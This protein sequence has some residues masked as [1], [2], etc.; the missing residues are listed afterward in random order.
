[1]EIVGRE[2]TD[3]EMAIL[4]R[5]TLTTVD[6]GYEESTTRSGDDLGET[7]ATAIERHGDLIGTDTFNAMAN[8]VSLLDEKL[9]PS[10][11]GQQRD[12]VNAADRLSGHVPEQSEQS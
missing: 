4:Y 7:L 3:K 6:E 10:L 11:D 2:F 12:F 9:Q 1:M 8:A 5:I